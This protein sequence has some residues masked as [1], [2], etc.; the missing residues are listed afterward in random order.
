VFSTAL[1]SYHG[2]PDPLACP[3]ERDRRSIATYYYTALEGSAADVKQ[4]TTT[5]QVRPGS[6][7]RTDWAVKSGHFISDWVPPRLQRYARRLNPFR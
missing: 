1:D 3:P 5:F 7:D 4:R 6:S 2:D